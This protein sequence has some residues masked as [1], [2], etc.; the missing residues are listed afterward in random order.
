LSSHNAKANN[1]QHPQAIFQ[2]TPP[3]S[4]GQLPYSTQVSRT[5]VG[6]QNPYPGSPISR[7]GN[8]PLASHTATPISQRPAQQPPNSF[9][10]SN[11]PQRPAQQPYQEMP[12]QTRPT[13]NFHTQ[14]GYGGTPAV[15]GV[16]PYPSNRG[17]HVSTD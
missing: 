13:P 15:A 11:P 16:P 1:A 4:I 12:P 5:E 9:A 8:S 17:F 14:R 2:S 6:K 7:G 3:S 10:P